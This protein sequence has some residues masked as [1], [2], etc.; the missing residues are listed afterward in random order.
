MFKI[1]RLIIL[2]AVVLGV[3]FGFVYGL[4][5]SAQRKRRERMEREK[6]QV[7]QR[8]EALAESRKRG[9]LTKEQADELAWQVYLDAKDR[10]LDVT[11]GPV[12][13]E[14]RVLETERSN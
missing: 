4:V 2:F 9:E 3:V 13:D 5:Q 8:L 12:G 10:G 6:E 14:E 11:Q 1:V 7:L